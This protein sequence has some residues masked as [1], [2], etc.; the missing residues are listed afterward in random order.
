MIVLSYGMTK[1]AS[2]FAW[3]VLKEILRLGG[4]RPIDL[5]PL[6]RHH[7]SSIDFVDPVDEPELKLVEIE[8]GGRSVVV[9]THSAI[10]DYVAVLVQRRPTIIF[11]SHRDPR[12]IALSL[13]DHGARSRASGGE[14]FAECLD[15]DSTTPMVAEQVR[16][17]MTWVRAQDV[18][19]YSVYVDYDALCFDTEATLVKMIERLE[20]GLREPVCADYVAA[21]FHDKS[22][23]PQFNKGAP[24]RWEREMSETVSERYLSEFASYYEWRDLR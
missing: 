17:L 6:A 5:S 4:A 3:L 13:M 23:I 18:Q 8:S 24:R 7:A 11:L 16:R 15:H 21:S 10:S 9:K 2:S 12:D 14:D 20:P 22:R 19:P 1:S